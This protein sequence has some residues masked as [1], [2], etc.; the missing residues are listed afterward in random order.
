MPSVCNLLSFSKISYSLS[1]RFV[2]FGDESST[3]RS[4]FD[5]QD[6][7]VTC[8]TRGRSLWLAIAKCPLKGIQKSIPVIVRQIGIQTVSTSLATILRDG[9]GTGEGKGKGPRLSS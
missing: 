1:H 5:F 7:V 2:V 9:P 6:P 3:H 4:R 8:Q